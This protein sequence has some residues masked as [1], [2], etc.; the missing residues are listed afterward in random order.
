MVALVGHRYTIYEFQSERELVT[1]IQFLS[2][3]LK[4]N[5]SQVY[6]FRVPIWKR[7]GLYDFWVSDLK[8]ILS[9]VYGFWVPILKRTGVKR[10]NLCWPQI[11][12]PSIER[13]NHSNGLLMF[14]FF[15]MVQQAAKTEAVYEINRVWNQGKIEKQMNN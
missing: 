12:D 7:F 11:Y 14:V 15:K 6:D 3:D 2:S 5:W 8:V 4:V 13:L 9:Q 1:G 10:N